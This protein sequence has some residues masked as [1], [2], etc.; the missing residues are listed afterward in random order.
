MTLNISPWVARRNG[1]IVA[2]A[3]R[4]PVSMRYFVRLCD[5]D[6]DLLPWR[7]YIVDRDRWRA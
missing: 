6:R 4:S 2:A 5:C 3:G 1:V 7:C